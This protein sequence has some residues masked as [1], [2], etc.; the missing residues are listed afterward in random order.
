[1]PVFLL[2]LVAHGH[3]LGLPNNN[4]SMLTGR[5]HQAAI[6]ISAAVTAVSTSAAEGREMLLEI[7][8]ATSVDVSCFCQAVLKLNKKQNNKE[9]MI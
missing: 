7:R 9:N 5:G 2:A 6:K 1:M 3:Q 8:S 4:A